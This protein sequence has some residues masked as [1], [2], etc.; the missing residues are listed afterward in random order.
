M[1]LELKE[2]PWKLLKRNRDR[3]MKTNSIE[4]LNKKKRK[5]KK[6]KFLRKFCL[7]GNPAPDPRPRQGMTRAEHEVARRQSEFSRRASA[8]LLYRH[9]NDI[10]RNQ[11]GNDTR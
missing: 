6:K 10:T 9:H 4:G 7:R 5:K 2:T 1:R 3:R 11:Q 8:W